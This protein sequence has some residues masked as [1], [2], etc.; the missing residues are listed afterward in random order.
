MSK[1]LRTLIALLCAVSFGV[2]GFSVYKVVETDR[3]SRSSVPAA[4]VAEAPVS[5]QATIVSADSAQQIAPVQQ[6]APAQ[7]AADSGAV[8][9]YSG[10][11]LSWQAGEPYYS[12]Y[13]VR[14]DDLD[15]ETLSLFYSLPMTNTG[16]EDLKM[17]DIT[18]ELI[19]RDGQVKKSYIPTIPSTPFLH[20]GETGWYCLHCI[21]VAEDDTISVGLSFML[22]QPVDPCIRL[23]VHDVFF[24]FENDQITCR[25]ENNTDTGF[26]T[27]S[28]WVI[29]FDESGH[30]IEMTVRPVLISELLAPG[31]AS[32]FHLDLFSRFTNL[33]KVPYSRYE[34]FAYP[35][36]MMTPL[37]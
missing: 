33:T 34:I 2:C 27:V 18:S 25:V 31:E 22:R 23:P 14:I 1:G 6:A 32:E 8:T 10:K 12:F 21:D 17:P 5:D 28:V 13:K 20:P 26:D 37:G 15:Y 4:A 35:I 3:A 19:G 7:Q 29:F 11:G 9:S 30:V 36:L 24:D 16:S